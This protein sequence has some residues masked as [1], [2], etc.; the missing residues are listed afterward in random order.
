MRHRRITSENDLL[1]L[2]F[3]FLPSLFLSDLR[4]EVQVFIHTQL[5]RVNH[6]RRPKGSQSSREKGRDES[7]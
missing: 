6:P 2:V 3:F 5:L 4:H 1:F 7:F